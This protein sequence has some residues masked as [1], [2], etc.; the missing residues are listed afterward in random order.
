MLLAPS[1]LVAEVVYPAAPETLALHGH[2]A[3]ATKKSLPVFTGGFLVLPYRGDQSPYRFVGIAFDYENYSRIHAFVRNK[4][5]TF[6]FYGKIPEG[7]TEFRYRL[8]VDS[9][10]QHDSGNP[11]IE[12]D[13]MGIKISRFV[14]ESKDDPLREKLGP[15]FNRDGSIDFL[16]RGQAGV[17]SFILGNF[18]QWDPFMTPMKEISP[19]LYKV[20]LRLRPGRYY[21]NFL[22]NGQRIRDPNNFFQGMGSGGELVSVLDVPVNTAEAGTIVTA[23]NR[24]K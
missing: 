5:G 2:I 22:F 24:S 4:K 13:H 3:S 23:S 20:T 9:V 18:N 21:Y 1:L 7:I 6:V 8:V 11:D 14:V 19:G 17:Y 12:M 15:Q 10:W 16:L